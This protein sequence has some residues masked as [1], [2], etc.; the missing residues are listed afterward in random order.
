MSE[1]TT[2]DLLGLPLTSLEFEGKTYEL[3][4]PTLIERGQ[5]QRWL[6]DE[7]RAAAHRD[8][9]TPDPEKDRFAVN[10]AIAGG[11]CEFDGELATERRRTW[12]GQAKL[13]EIMFNLDPDAA[14]RLVKENAE[15]IAEVFRRAVLDHDPKAVGALVG[16]LLRTLG[17]PHD[18]LSDAFS[19]SSDPKRRKPSGGSPSRNSGRSSAR[20]GATGKRVNSSSRQ[21]VAKPSASR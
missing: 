7:L 13:Y 19:T 9:D 5:Y 15:R 20:K 17:L 16:P 4:E 1:P 8:T 21:A 6:E 14:E 2:A 3:R 10:K 11:V 12:S 18:F